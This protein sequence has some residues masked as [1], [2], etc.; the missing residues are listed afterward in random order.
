M[1]YYLDEIESKNLLKNLRPLTRKV[2]VSE[3]LRGWNWNR[4]PL[5][6]YRPVLLPMYLICS[7]YCPTSRDLYLKRVEKRRGEWNHPLSLGKV[8]HDTVARAYT[9]AREGEF[10]V[11]FDDWYRMQRYEDYMK[12]N[13]PLIQTYARMVYDYILS[14]ARSQFNV[15]MSSHPF[16]AKR[17]MLLASVPFLVEHTINGE[18]LGCSSVLSIDC[19]D[20]LHN[21][22]FDLKVGGNRDET[23]RLQPAGYA[24]VFESIYEIPV[25]IGGTVYLWFQNNQLIARKDLFPIGDHLRSWWLE[26]RDRRAELVHEERDP[27]MPAECPPSCIYRSVCGV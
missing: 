6:P 14:Q 2:G 15:A 1:V 5:S 21:I 25:D 16:S 17:D 19:Y 23:H 22:I 7:N 11:P 24:L 26:M 27:G 9:L 4:T 10:D 20:Y 3:D 13:L 8:I 18:L 12:G